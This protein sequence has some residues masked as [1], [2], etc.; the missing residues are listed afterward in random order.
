MDDKDKPLVTPEPNGD[1]SDIESIPL[2]QAPEQTQVPVQ[3][4]P[5]VPVEAVA[6][7]SNAPVPP[8]KSKKGIIIAAIIAGVMVVLFAGTALA[9]NY[10]YQNPNKVVTD[11]LINASTAKSVV[12]TGIIDVTGDQKVKIEFNGSGEQSSGLMNVKATFNAGGKQVTVEGAALVDKNSNIY[13]KIKDAKALVTNALGGY[14]TAFDDIVTKIDNKWVKITTDDLSEYSTET[15]NVKKC[16]DEAYAKFKD[17]KAA[18]AEVTNAYKANQFIVIGKTL[19]S[20][21]GSLGYE[22]TF[23]DAKSESFARAFTQ[24]TIYKQLHECDSESFPATYK[25]SNDKPVD[26]E[27]TTQ[28]WVSRFGHEI[29]KFV[30]DVD[31]DGTKTHV[32]IET[33]F[34]KRVT[35]DVPT[36]FVTVDELKQDIENLYAS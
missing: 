6:Q 13:I 26:N 12:F 36:E 15:K 35:I 29:T 7:P 19:P 21:N 9:Y 3:P 16:I 4:L 14:E 18:I 31:N 2:R 25:P 30:T 11:A 17:D 1:S 20:Q 27:G 8:K 10:W 33:L 28:L 22:I 32:S 5:T 23:D 24:T 34:N